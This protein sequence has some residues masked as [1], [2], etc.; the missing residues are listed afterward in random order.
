MW[1]SISTVKFDD[2]IM[3]HVN[4]LYKIWDYSFHSGVHCIY[5]LTEEDRFFQY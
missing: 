2:V 5:P 1:Q 3:R 4:C